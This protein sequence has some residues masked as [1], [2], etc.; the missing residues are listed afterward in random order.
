MTKTQKLDL[1]LAVYVTCVVAAE[2]LGAKIF[3]IAGVINSSVA[4]FVFPIT[5]TINDII[6]EVEGKERARSFVRAGFYILVGLAVYTLLAIT[7]PPADRFQDN[8]AYQTIFAKSLRIIVASLAAFYLAERFDIYVFS[9]I[10]QRLGTGKL[11]L[12][13]NLS[14]FIGQLFDTTIFMFLAFFQPGNFTFI[15]SLIWPYWLLKCLMSI[16]ET[17]FTYLGVKWLRGNEVENA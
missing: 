3:T 17:P 11:W 8:V 14:N 16:I 2:L 12:R 5:F 10:R 6:T 4:I 1:M 13:N 7:L 9:Q 15:L